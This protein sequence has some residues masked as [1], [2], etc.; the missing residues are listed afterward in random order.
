VLRDEY[1]AATINRAVALIHLER[2]D[3]AQEQR[4]VVT[5]VAAGHASYQQGPEDPARSGWG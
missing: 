4:D 5:T 1:W 2:Y 3:E